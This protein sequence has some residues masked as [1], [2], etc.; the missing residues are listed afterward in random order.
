MFLESIL[1]EKILSNLFCI[2]MYTKLSTHVVGRV[3]SSDSYWQSTS[4]SPYNM[5]IYCG[6]LCEKELMPN[7]WL[8]VSY[9]SYSICCV[10]PLITVW[11]LHPWPENGTSQQ[12]HFVDGICVIIQWSRSGYRNSPSSFFKIAIH[13]IF[14]DIFVWVSLLISF[15]D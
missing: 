10:D 15:W 8:I 1:A 7:K 2:L 13:G 9:I 5:C 14:F 4:R 6:S 3:I 11:N 12:W